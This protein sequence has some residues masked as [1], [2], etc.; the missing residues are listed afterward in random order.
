MKL[1]SHVFAFTVYVKQHLHWTDMIF[2]T[3]N[4]STTPHSTHHFWPALWR[5]SWQRMEVCPII[6]L[7]SHHNQKLNSKSTMI[8][9]YSSG[10]CGTSCWNNICSSWLESSFKAGGYNHGGGGG[11]DA[12][13]TNICFPWILD[14]VKLAAF[15]FYKVIESFIKADPTLSK[16]IVK[17]LEACEN[18]IMERIAWRT[19]SF[20][21]LSAL[22]SG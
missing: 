18:L 4:S 11:G 8:N 3:V 5:W 21:S 1:C 20:I 17:H 12:A 15:D 6:S 13:E 16:D 9:D 7:H 22:Q 19:V 14:V 10:R 2:I